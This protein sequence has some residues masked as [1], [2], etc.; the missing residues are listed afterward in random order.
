MSSVTPTPKS[1]RCSGSGNDATCITANVCSSRVCGSAPQDAPF[2]RAGNVDGEAVGRRACVIRPFGTG[3]GRRARRRTRAAHG[4]CA[5]RCRSSSPV[6]CSMRWRTCSHD[7]PVPSPTTPAPGTVDEQEVGRAGHVVGSHAAL[8]ITTGR[9]G[10]ARSA[11][12]GDALFGRV[13][14]DDDQAHVGRQVEAGDVV[15]RVPERRHVRH[16]LDRNASSVRC[17]TPTTEICI[18]SSRKPV[19]TMSA[20]ARTGARDVDEVDRRATRRL[21]ARRRAR[22]GGAGCRRGCAT[23]PATSTVSN[24][25]TT[26]SAAMIATVTTMP[27]DELRGRSA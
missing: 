17:G 24:A 11:Q 7:A 1:P 13:L 10:G 5:P 23:S 25:S 12:R 20:H 19:P 14:R 3:S 15:E 8:D 18:A 2:P 27:P 22:A 26:V 4:R 9:S 6:A 21:R 16:P